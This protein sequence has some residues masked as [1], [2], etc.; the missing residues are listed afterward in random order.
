M[1]RAALMQAATSLQGAA[2]KISHYHLVETR[3]PFLEIGLGL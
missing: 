3:R 1:K 2:F